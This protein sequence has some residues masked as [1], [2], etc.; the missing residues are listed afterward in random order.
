[1]WRE[2]HHVLGIKLLMSTT[3]HPQTDGAVERANWTVA[4]ILCP[5]VAS[6]Q[7]DWAQQLPAVELA[8]NS[9]ISASTGFA[10][11][12]LNY[13]WLPCLIST[14]VVTTPYKGVQQWAEWAAEDLE[15]AFDAIIMSCVT[16]HKQANS[17]HRADDPLLEVGSKAY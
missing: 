12:E 16:Q 9:S 8:I 4:Q 14:P 17:R 15:R 10:P 6:D 13:G 2:L 11:F 1:M 3:F 7:H 5:M